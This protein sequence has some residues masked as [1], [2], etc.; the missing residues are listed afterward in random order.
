M[1]AQRGQVGRGAVALVL[2]EAVLRVPHVQVLHVAVARDLG[3]DRGG[4][5]RAVDAITAD[6]RLRRQHQA[7]GHDV[8]IDAGEAGH[9]GHGRHH[10]AHALQGGLVDVQAVDGVH[11][12]QHHFPGQGPFDDAVM[13]LLAARCGQLLGIIQAVDARPRR[14]EH[15]GGHGY[16]A[17]Q[18][19]AAG[20]VDAGHQTFGLDHCRAVE[21]G[22]AGHSGS[23]TAH[24]VSWLRTSSSPT[25][26]A[27]RAEALRRRRSCRRS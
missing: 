17:G 11:V 14:V 10:I 8:A 13:Q 27:A 2:V 7:L 19:P 9:V 4:H 1:R 21:Q 12:H 20:F 25:A 5:D 26:S 18:G 3:Q 16:R 24:A 22:Q 23:A 6:Q 15:H